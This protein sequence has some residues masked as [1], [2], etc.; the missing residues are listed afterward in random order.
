MKQT[1]CEQRQQLAAARR[2]V[3]KLG[4]R[5]LVRASGQL[6]L[7][8]LS[9]LVDEIAALRRSGREVVLVTSG[10]IGAGMHVLGLKRRPSQLP[11]LQMAAAVGQSRLM[12][13]YD[14]L[15]TAAGC[16]IGQ[17]LLTHEDL[18]Q[19]ARHLNARNAI[20]AMLRRGVIPIVNEND[21]VAVDEIKFGDNDRLAALV[22]HL[23]NADLLVLLTSTN[24]LRRRGAAGRSSRLALVPAI[25][26][27]ILKLASGKGSQLSSGGMLSKL[28]SAGVAG[29]AGARVVIADGRQAGIL[30]RVLTGADT[31]TLIL[32]AA[33]RQ[34]ARARWIGFFH[35][36]QGCLIID[37]GARRALEENGKSLLPVGILKVQGDF[38]AGATVEVKASD[39][40]LIARGLSA[41]ASAELRLIQ[42]RPTNAIAAILGRPPCGEAIHRDNLILMKN[43]QLPGPGPASAAA[44]AAPDPTCHA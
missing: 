3:I 28:E 30:G 22:V 4:S 11:D 33:R 38:A 37:G 26:A 23:L 10:A 32:P 43:N 35:K 15:F 1:S 36:P 14:R 44:P 18:K 6:E 34:G 42:G 39:Q 20:G 40:T 27:D 7:A 29:Q 17:V 12:N 8:R 31:G 16:L 25:T 41:Y 19:R 5:I 24:G 2:V 13:V 21:T 9:G